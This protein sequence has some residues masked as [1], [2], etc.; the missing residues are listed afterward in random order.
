VGQA[1]H[2]GFELI[3]HLIER[4]GQPA[5]LTLVGDAE[6]GQRAP[7]CDLVRDRGQAA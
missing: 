1:E 5:D 6:N 3:G 7:A 2:L 4:F